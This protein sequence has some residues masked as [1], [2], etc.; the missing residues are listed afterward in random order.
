[1]VEDDGAAV[2]SDEAR[3]RERLA[4]LSMRQRAEMLGG[5]LNVESR[6]QA[7]TTF[8]TAVS[9]EVPIDPQPAF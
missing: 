1:M 2:T 4:L 5:S 3:R 7:D 9:A 8:G 6:L